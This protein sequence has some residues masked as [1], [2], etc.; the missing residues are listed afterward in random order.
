MRS[1]WLGLAVVTLALAYNPFNNYYSDLLLSLRLPLLLFLLVF[2]LPLV[3]MKSYKLALF[4]ASF[5]I[6]GLFFLS[7]LKPLNAINQS[8][9]IKTNSA[10]TF[11]VKQ[12]NLSYAN[13][14]L[15]HT[16]PDLFA[17]EWDLLILQEF[18]D[19]HRDL[20]TAYLDEFDMYGYEHTQGSPYGLLILSRI[21]LIYSEKIALDGDRLGYLKLTL[22]VN[23]TVVTVFVA[24]PPSPRTHAFW[25]QRNQ[26]LGALQQAVN[27]HSGPWLIAGDLN[28]VSWSDYFINTQGSSCIET[29]G[30]YASW[31]PIGFFADIGL[32]IDHCIYSRALS[33]TEFSL[34]PF[35]GSD[36]LLLSYHLTINPA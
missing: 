15:T 1:V 32:G 18:N 20:L 12:I 19:M 11:L 3:C 25:L 17:Q 14:Y 10:H 9:A 33:L 22:L 31:S 23:D 13:P 36:H 27:T 6:V 2:A 7:H 30:Y 5:A 8:H 24:H 29:V 34:H 16:L 26:L 4:V 35:I 28:T 21:P